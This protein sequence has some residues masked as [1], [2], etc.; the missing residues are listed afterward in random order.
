[1][2]GV[3]EAALL[4]FVGLY[5]VPLALRGLHDAPLALGVL[6]DV[7]LVLVP[8]QQP[9]QCAL[10]SLLPV[11]CPRGGPSLLL[12]PLPGLGQL[13]LTLGPEPG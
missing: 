8:G 13:L 4:V 7:P 9:Q 5:N 12:L 11:L 3:L 1:M 2:L 10:C 6:E